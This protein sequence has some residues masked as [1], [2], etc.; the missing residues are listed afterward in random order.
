MIL[1]DSIF[2][3]ILIDLNADLFKCLYLD[4]FFSESILKVSVSRYF[5]GEYVKSILFTD[6]ILK[7]FVSRYFFLIVS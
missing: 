1:D 2:F 5:F 3:D 7:V 4:T 6:S